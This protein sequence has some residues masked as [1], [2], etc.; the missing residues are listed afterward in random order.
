MRLF[1]DSGDG[2]RQKKMRLNLNLYYLK[3]FFLLHIW[4][5]NLKNPKD[6][7]IVQ[8]LPIKLAISINCCRILEIF[9]RKNP[10]EKLAK[11]HSKDYTNEK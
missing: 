11:S 10:P 2:I 3:W 5:Q 9:D 6:T 8:K 1:G 7:L 4:I